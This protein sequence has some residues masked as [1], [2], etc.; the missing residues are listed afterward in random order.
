MALTATIYG[1]DIQ[2]SGNPIRIK[3]AGGTAPAGSTH[4][5]YTLKVISVDG[6]LAGAPFI[7]AIAPDGAGEALFDISGLVDQPVK[8]AFEYPESTLIKS[9]TNQVFSI[10]AQPGESYI[11]SNGDLQETWG[12]ES[13]TFSCIKGGVSQRQLNQWLTNSTNFYTTYIVAK[14]WLTLRPWGDFVHPNQPVKLFFMTSGTVTLDFVITCYFDDA[15]STTITRSTTMNAGNIYEYMCNPKSHGTNLQPTGKRATH[16]DC[17]LKSGGTNYSNSFRFTYDWKSCERPY[18][19]MFAN[20]IGGVDDVFLAG[21]AEESFQTEGTVVTRPATMQDD[22]VDPTLIIPN[23]KGRNTWSI[24]TGWK[25]ASQMRHLRD[26][27]LSRQA[28]LLYPNLSVS[29][30]IVIPVIVEPGG[31]TIVNYMENIFA[32]EIEIIEAHDN[33]YGFDNS[34]Y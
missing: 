15:S 11:D 23:R 19:L 22:V 18:F 1:G 17:V 20:S 8:K 12:T 16:F 34:L 29:N 27:M 31:K 30:Y 7:D 3:V 32:M 24:S 4:Y 28:W 9:Y 13:E 5:K 21:F 2:L 10:K 26:L 14:R 25:T 6:E 33:M